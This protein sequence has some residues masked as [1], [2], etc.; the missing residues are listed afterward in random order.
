MVEAVFSE[1]NKKTP[2]GLRYASLA[3]EDGTFIHI[4]EQ[5]DNAPS[6]S[7]FVKFQEGVDERCDELPQ[8]ADAAIVG[9]YRMFTE[10]GDGR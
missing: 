10:T 7:A 1:L 8:P 2:A 4:V 3:L 6:M 9:N 5:D